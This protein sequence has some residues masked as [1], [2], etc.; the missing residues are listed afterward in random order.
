M[1]DNNWQS[2]FTQTWNTAVAD[3]KNGRQSPSSM[4]SSQETLAFLQ[5]I[6]CS[7]QELFDFVD[8]HL[9]YGEPS[10]E[11]TLEVTAIRRDYFL[12][13]QQGQHSNH[14][15]NMASLPAKSDAANGIPWL[16]R[17][18]AKARIK[19]RG[20]MPPELMY[21]CSGDRAFLKKINMSLPQ[22]LSLVRNND[23]DQT[24]INTVTLASQ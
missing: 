11:T 7:P 8:D 2:T 17:I 12:Q 14:T 4:F 21:G 24:I 9:T 13:D 22:F 10:L 3:W 16:P 6:G 23:N 19:L 1:H 15:A 5:S 20:E 18:I